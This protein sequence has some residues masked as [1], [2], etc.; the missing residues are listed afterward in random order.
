MEK[1]KLY[2]KNLDLVKLIDESISIY[3][4]LAKEKQIDLKLEYPSQKVFAVCTRQIRWGK[5]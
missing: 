4:E 2:L 1:S 5:Q 3:K